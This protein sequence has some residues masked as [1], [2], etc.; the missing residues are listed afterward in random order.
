MERFVAGYGLVLGA[1]L[2]CGMAADLQVRAA[3]T[4]VIS[5]FMA[6]NDSVVKDAEGEFVDW[7]EV[8]NYGEEPVDLSGFYLTDSRR[9]LSKWPIGNSSL[10]AGAFLTLFTTEKGADW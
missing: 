9:E 7:I 6:L 2:F 5:E 4:L 3:Q 1:A 8:H 10:E